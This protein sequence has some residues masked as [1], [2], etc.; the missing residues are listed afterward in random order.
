MIIPKSAVSEL[1][2]IDCIATAESRI[3]KDLVCQVNADPIII[4]LQSMINTVN[5]DIRVKLGTSQRS[6]KSFVPTFKC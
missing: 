4:K 3:I 2:P 5:E 6:E 1:T